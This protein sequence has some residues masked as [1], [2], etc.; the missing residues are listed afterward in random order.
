M[1]CWFPSW[2]G[3][4]RKQLITYSTQI[5]GQE[6]YTN[7]I[8]SFFIFL[9]LFLGRYDVFPLTCA[10]F[11]FLIKLPWVWSSEIWRISPLWL[12]NLL[13]TYVILYVASTRNGWHWLSTSFVRW[14]YSCCVTTK[15]DSALSIAKHLFFSQLWVVLLNS[16][17]INKNYDLSLFMLTWFSSVIFEFWYSFTM[18]ILIP[19]GNNSGRLFEI[20]WW[21]SSC[22]KKKAFNVKVSVHLG[23]SQRIYGPL[24][25]HNGMK[26]FVW[27]TWAVG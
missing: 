27:P 21:T 12:V 25:V 16:I 11:F 1:L 4:T 20:F 5:L 15:L 17:V 14:L 26:K 22:K 24:V 7:S 2:L 10:I 23:S 3:L 9:E 19:Q 18:D 8:S 6:W 13:P